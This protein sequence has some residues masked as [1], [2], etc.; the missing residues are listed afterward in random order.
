MNIISEKNSY[1]SKGEYEAPRLKRSSF[2]EARNDY[3][4]SND[5]G[6]ELRPT[7]RKSQTEGDNKSETEAKVNSPKLSS[8][9]ENKKSPLSSR[10]TG[11]SKV[12][13]SAFKD[14]KPEMLDR[15]NYKTSK[16]L[17]KRD[18]EYSCSRGSIMPSNKRGS[19]MSDRIDL[20]GHGSRTGSKLTFL[21]RSG[22]NE[23]DDGY[24]VE[25]ITSP[26]WGIDGDGR[27]FSRD[28]RKSTEPRTSHYERSSAKSVSIV[29]TRAKQSPVNESKRGSL[30]D[31]HKTEFR[32]DKEHLFGYVG[33]TTYLQKHSTFSIDTLN[34]NGIDASG[35][36]RDIYDANYGRHGA[37]LA[38]R[39]YSHESRVDNQPSIS[40]FKQTSLTGSKRVPQDKSEFDKK[41][42]YNHN[43]SGS[44]YNRN[45]S[46][47][48][49]R[50]TKGA[51]Y[52]EAKSDYTGDINDD[53]NIG[54]TKYDSYLD[55]SIVDSFIQ[56][57]SGRSTNTFH[58]LE[59]NPTN[60]KS[61][62]NGARL[63]KFDEFG[64]QEFDMRI[65]GPV[66][67][68]SRSMDRDDSKRIKNGKNYFRSIDGNVE[69]Q[70]NKN[71]SR[72]K[73]AKYFD[74]DDSRIA[75][76]GSEIN[77]TLSF[78]YEHE[79]IPLQN[80]IK[81]LKED[82]DVLAKQQVL[83]KEKLHGP[84]RMKPVKKCPCFK[85]HDFSSILE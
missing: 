17:S 68:R 58:L 71:V 81:G 61:E 29:D 46:S 27:S 79:L 32:D 45:E 82:I 75:I 24:I 26:R 43:R 76:I 70:F 36:P 77:R 11:E 60:S 63:S 10:N 6:F 34:K 4:S 62:S 2:N 3:T 73:V 22:L 7:N 53:R 72:N 80:V 41:S 50:S 18:S 35:Y 56:D 12:S 67:S 49:T 16:K 48:K 54:I 51:T 64:N 19:F 30:D 42:Y 74:Q 31:R 52:N 21:R 1:S 38:K 83:L 25:P 23:T 15:N 5:P 20:L 69:S 33:S 39:I 66:H 84:K 65:H 28:D 47:T 40:S 57:K 55:T 9:P 37:V 78:I 85:R 8:K 14:T 44:I 59:D 13:S